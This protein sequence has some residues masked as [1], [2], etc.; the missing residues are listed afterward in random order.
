[1]YII[2]TLFYSTLSS[3]YVLH[4]TYAPYFRLCQIPDY[5]LIPAKKISRNRNQMLFKFRII[6]LSLG[7]IF[8][9]QEAYEKGHHENV[10]VCFLL[11][12]IFQ[13]AGS[14]RNVSFNPGRT[15]RVSGRNGR[16]YEVHLVQ[17]QLFP[18]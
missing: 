1:M 18:F 7:E 2:C 13:Y 16:M 8:M 5:I 14:G 3:S 12:S 9:D 10:I 17:Y 4:S 15:T 11:F 6:S